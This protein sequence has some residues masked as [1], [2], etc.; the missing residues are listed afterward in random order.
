M[1]ALRSSSRRRAFS[2]SSFRTFFASRSPEGIGP[3]FLPSSRSDPSRV[4]TAPRAAAWRPISPGVSQAFL[5]DR[6]LVCRREAPPR[7]FAVNP[8]PAR[9]L[10]LKRGALRSSSFLL[11]VPS[12]NLPRPTLAFSPFVSRPCWQ[13]GSG[14]FLR[15]DSLTGPVHLRS[16]SCAARRVP[17]VIH[18]APDECRCLDLCFCR[19]L[20]CDALRTRDRPRSRSLR[21]TTTHVVG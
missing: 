12:C 15:T 17:V 2:R 20:D 8:D 3:R 16:C 6:Q 18:V 10:R 9:L 13:R 19:D 1:C 7:A 14:P 4:C 11:L 5:D 21:R